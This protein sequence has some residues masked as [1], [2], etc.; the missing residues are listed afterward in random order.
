[1]K[2]R[3]IGQ[4][5]NQ[6]IDESIHTKELLIQKEV[7]RWI[8]KLIFF[9]RNKVRRGASNDIEQGREWIRMQCDN[10]ASDCGYNLMVIWEGDPFCHC[11]GVLGA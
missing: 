9:M 6:L 1:M 8:K 4:I 3:L 11:F 7:G 10:V 5:G 2:I